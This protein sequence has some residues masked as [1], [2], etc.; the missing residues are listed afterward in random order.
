MVS[1]L[2]IKDATYSIL[3][4]VI[5][6]TQIDTGIVPL[7]QKIIV[8]YQAKRNM[9]RKAII[10]TIGQHLKNSILVI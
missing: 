8:L 5:R 7:I 10:Y 4:L 3:Q 1:S 9:I 6:S 2:S